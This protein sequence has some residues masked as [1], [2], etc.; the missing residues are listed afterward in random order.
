MSTVPV[1]EKQRRT[2]AP[3]F[4]ENLLSVAALTAMT[5]LPVSEMVARQFHMGGITGAA[6]IVQQL[7]LW[8]GFL[9]AALAARSG[10]LLSLSASTFL[11]DRWRALA[12]IVAFGVLATISLCLA[13]AS[14]QFVQAEKQGGSY[15]LQDLLPKWMAVAI[16]P[17]GFAV[18]ALRAVWLASPRWNGRTLAAAGLIIPIAVYFAGTPAP[19]PVFVVGVLTMIAATFLGLPIFAVFGGFAMLLFWHVGTPIASV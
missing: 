11:P 13:W 3:E 18:I 7:T 9:G 2:S 8:I 6:V 17:V 4:L 19:S 1:L 12:R 15:V 5:L 14:L 10:N 16:M